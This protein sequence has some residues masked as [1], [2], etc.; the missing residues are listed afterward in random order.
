V[1]KGDKGG[2]YYVPDGADESNTEDQVSVDD[3]TNVDDNPPEPNEIPSDIV[4]TE[5]IGFEVPEERLR[6]SDYLNV[7]V[8][9]WD[10]DD[11]EAVDVDPLVLQFNEPSLDGENIKDILDADP[12]DLPPIEGYQT[13]S[14]D[15]VVTDG[16]HRAAAAKVAGWDNLDMKLVNL[17]EFDDISLSAGDMDFRDFVGISESD[18]DRELQDIE[19]IDTGDYPD[20]AVENAQMALD[21]REET[22]NPNDCGTRVGWER[23]NQLVNG[24]DLSED[25]IERMASFARHEDNKEQGEEG[26]A[27]CGWMMWKAWGGDEGIAWAENKSDAIDQARENS[28]GETGFRTCGTGVTDDDIANAPEWDRP[29]LE[30]Y[31]GVTNPESD[32]SRPTRSRNR[33]GSP[34]TVSQSRSWTLR[35][36]SPAT[37]PSELRER[38]PAP[39]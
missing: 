10:M 7:G 25:T 35:V 3:A 19:D 34:L 5:E 26:R 8:V 6:G 18:G 24:E 1:I 9:A 39:C 32:P 29:L 22:G 28:A 23:A 14:G 16:N 30:M 15:I 11:S 33:R 20:A 36:T 17:S 13:E 2:L 4:D 12:D 27:D 21:A 37:K 38:S 31:Q